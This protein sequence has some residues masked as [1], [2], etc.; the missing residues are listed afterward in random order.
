M[1]RYQLAYDH[2]KK[3]ELWKDSIANESH[4]NQVKELELK[5]ETEKKEK[6]IALLA[7]EKETSD[8]GN[9]AAGYLKT[10]FLRRAFRGAADR[11]FVDL[12]PPAAHQN[13][14]DAHGQE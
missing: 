5:Y 3:F 8:Q 11:R 1:G 13:A 7:Q 2:R 9:P 4:L 14:K 6:Q 10:S 12:Y